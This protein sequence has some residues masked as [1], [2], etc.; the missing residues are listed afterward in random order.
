[1]DV[2]KK[3]VDNIIGSYHDEVGEQVKKAKSSKTAT[4]SE[5]IVENII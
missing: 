2:A 1:M 3:T 4:S 5:E